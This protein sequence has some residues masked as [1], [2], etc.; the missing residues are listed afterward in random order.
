MR[1]PSGP[2]RM[3]AWRSLGSGIKERLWTGIAPQPVQLKSR[4]SAIELAGRFW[5]HQ[6]LWRVVP[7]NANAH[8]DQLEQPYQFCWRGQ[9]GQRHPRQL[10]IPSGTRGPRA[11]APSGEPGGETER[12]KAKL[13]EQLGPSGY[14][15][16]KNRALPLGWG[17][18]HP[19]PVWSQPEVT[20]RPP[21]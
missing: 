18:T 21:N 15:K 19:L 1:L 3:A 6:S 13:P 8:K 5:P 2:W 16:L 11:V 17:E 10:F 4:I 12:E 9:S 20:L 7:C 14:E